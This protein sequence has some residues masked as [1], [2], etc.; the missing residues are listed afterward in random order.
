M[1]FNL[2]FLFALALYVS[3]V[4]AFPGLAFPLFAV[5]LVALPDKCFA[6]RKKSV[7]LDT[8]PVEN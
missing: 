1:T 2:R 7:A 4:L 3:I 6:P 5:L 8:Q